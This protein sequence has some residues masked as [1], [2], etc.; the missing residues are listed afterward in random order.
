MACVDQV[1][2]QIANLRPVQGAVKQG[3]LAMQNRALQRP[4]CDVIVQRGPG[5][6]RENAYLAWLVS[7]LRIN[8]S[9]PPTFSRG[10]GRRETPDGCN[11]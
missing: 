9:N 11:V 5:A 6:T 10:H 4:F 7:L 2:E 3:V 8:F 1:H